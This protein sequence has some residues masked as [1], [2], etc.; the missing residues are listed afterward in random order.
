M[1]NHDVHNKGH[2]AHH[3]TQTRFGPRPVPQPYTR[4]GPDGTARRRPAAE[5][6]ESSLTSKLVVWGGMGIVAA[7]ATAGAVLATRKVAEAIAGDDEEPVTRRNSRYAP[8]FGN[9]PEDDREEVRRRVRAQAIADQ[10]EAAR[11]RAAAARRRSNAPRPAPTQHRDIAGDIT[12]TA[13][14]LTSSLN[15]IMQALSSAVTG[16]RG[17]ALQAGGIIREFSDAADTVRGVMGNV[18]Q[19]TGRQRNPQDAKP[20]F[21]RKRERV[22]TGGEGVHESVSGESDRLHRI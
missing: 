15:G 5:W 7:A 9:L 14:N 10:K 22:T 13:N 3:T 2:E 19:Q 11:M 6:P 4:L 1:T 16:F 20:S 18:S 21:E 12:A 8:R 17:V